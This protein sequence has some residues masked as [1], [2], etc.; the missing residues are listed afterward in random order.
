MKLKFR[1]ILALLVT[2]AIGYTACK[3]ATNTP[4]TAATITPKAMASEVALNLVSTLNGGAFGGFN[5]SNGL[6]APSKLVINRYKGRRISDLGDVLC[7][8]SFDTTFAATPFTG[9]GVSGS[10]SGSL[11]YVFSCT[12]GVLSGFNTIDNLNVT[13]TTS[14]VTGSFKIDE[15]LTLVSTNPSANDSGFKL[16]GTMNYSGTFSLLTGAK[17][18]GT[19][20][21][22]YTFTSLVYDADGN[23]LSGSATFN[24]KGTG[25][26]GTW[27][28]QGSIT[29]LGN[30]KATITINGTGYNVDLTTGLVS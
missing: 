29:F 17:Q 3:K 15:N 16:S 27:A 6:Q 8:S 2:I 9:G 19:S 1:L 7:G 30:G 24:T 13:E 11:K 18:S 4:T 14:Q 23:I 25:S 21:F 12:N 20:S 22:D 10:V 5:A 26:T 28:Y